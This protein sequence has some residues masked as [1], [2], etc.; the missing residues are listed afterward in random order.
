MSNKGRGAQNSI[1]MTVWAGERARGGIA[2]DRR[3][4]ST[5]GFSRPSLWREEESRSF[6]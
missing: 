4:G 2:Q 6:S 3:F 1:V 5:L